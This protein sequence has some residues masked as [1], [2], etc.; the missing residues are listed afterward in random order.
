MYLSI[1]LS[2]CFPLYRLLSPDGAIAY[3]LGAT[4]EH[5]E[6]LWLWV[7][8]TFVPMGTPFWKPDEP[9]NLDGNENCLSFHNF[10]GYFN[11]YAC[12]ME[13]YF[14]CQDVSVGFIASIYRQRDGDADAED[15]NILPGY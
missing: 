5:Q 8:G 6:H 10:T 14:I 2:Y 13:F 9:N 7:D 11:D 4:D 3:W 1:H 15:K 12:S